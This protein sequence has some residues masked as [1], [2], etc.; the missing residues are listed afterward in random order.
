MSWDGQTS[1]NDGGPWGSDPGSGPENPWGKGN[2]N[3]K[4]R[5]TPPD[6]ESL[7]QKGQ[8]CF[9]WGVLVAEYS[10]FLF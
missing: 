7:I 6:L 9:L 2:R 4:S 1:K 5:Q 10:S 8:E 3:Q